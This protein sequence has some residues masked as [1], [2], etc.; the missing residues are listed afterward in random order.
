[1]LVAALAALPLL[2]VVAYATID[3]YDAD[4][5][6]GPTRAT[7]R[8]Q[9]YAALLR[10][11]GSERPTPMRLRELLELSQPTPGSVVVVFDARGR[12]IARAGAP[13][14]GPSLADPA[15]REAIARGTGTF[16]ATGPDGVRRVWGLAPGAGSS[17]VAFGL[18]GQAVYGA[19]LTALKRDVALALLAAALAMLAAFLLA[20]R[21]TAPLRRLAARVG[22]E[23]GRANEIGALERRFSAL[24][25]AVAGSEDQLRHGAARLAALHAIDRAILDARTP[26]EIARAAIGRLRALVGAE[27]AEVLLFD[28][29]QRTAGS[30]AADAA[31][32]MAPAFAAVELDDELLGVPELREGRVTTRTDLAAYVPASP[33]ATRLIAA[34]VRCLTSV[35]LRADGELLGALKLGF[36]D[37]AGMTEEASTA[38]S[39]VADQLAIALRHA[40][41]YTELQAV[42]NAALDAIVVYDDELR[43]V[44]ANEAAGRLAGRPAEQLVG[45]RRD[46]FV[47]S[48]DR[49]FDLDEMR[50][51]GGMEGVINV[52]F[53]SGAKRVLEVRGRPEFLPGRHLFVLRDVTER[54][55]LEDQLRQSQKLEAVGQLAGGVAHDFNN[56]LTVIGGYGTVLAEQIADGPGAQDL[57]E[58][59]AATDRAGQLTKQLLAFSRRQVLDLGD[60]D[61][62]DV[63]QGLIPMLRRLIGEDIEVRVHGE[64]GLPSVRADRSQMEQVLMNLSVNAR[65][66]MPRGGTLT[67]ET[68]SVTLDEGYAREHAHIDPGRY[69]CMSVSDTGTGI[70]PETAAHLFEPFFTTKDVGHG[71]GLGLATVHGIVTQTGGEVF[72]YSEPGHGATFKLYLP[73]SETATEPSDASHEDVPAQLDGTET[74]LLCEDEPPVRRLVERVLAKHGYTVLAA[75]QPSQALELARANSATIGAAISDVIMPEMPG[76]ELATQLRRIRPGLPVLFVSGYTGDILRDRASLPAESVVVE[77]PFD[78]ATLLTALRGL[79]DHAQ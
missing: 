52:E 27:R 45:L 30:L 36:V 22:G 68:R 49:D 54:H 65:D 57:A 38:A 31:G 10:Q 5:A 15:V 62:G 46:Q 66:A 24:D 25:E 43:V 51:Q 56:L 71:T 69:V 76:P 28:R 61:L 64:Q 48:S 42:V 6:R 40:R 60:V 32:G 4:H 50:A 7:G 26:E 8:A 74:I 37:P 11:A 18:P 39:E 77:K 70:D 73:I 41:L 23:A 44:S 53:V 63:A 12:P 21:V 79:L 34:G 35:P 33:L 47:R 13:R 17:V 3:R 9:V 58:M 16:E 67:I 2:A 1:V 78:H 55:Q 20:G 29:E 72:V 19:A 14:A 59:L 75:E